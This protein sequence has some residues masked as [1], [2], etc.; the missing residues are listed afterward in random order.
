MQ[1]IQRVWSLGWIFAYSFYESTGAELIDT[2]LVSEQSARL[3]ND[4]LVSRVQ[5]TTRRQ[6]EACEAL[7]GFQI[8]HSLGGGTGAGLGCLL[9]SKI[10]EVRF[11]IFILFKN[12]TTIFKEFPDRMVATFSI[13]PSP[14]VGGMMLSLLLSEPFDRCQKQS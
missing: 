3:F 13:L 8:I 1:F 9:L 10:R 6:A 5:D 7:Q 14:K 2:I 12:E 11:V 4:S